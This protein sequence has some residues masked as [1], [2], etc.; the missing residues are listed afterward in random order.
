MGAASKLI[1]PKLVE[2]K[3]LTA[4]QL[5]TALAQQIKTGQALCSCAV[6][7]GFCA[8]DAALPFLAQELELGHVVL[9][10]R[11]IP[12][13]VVRKVPA[14]LAH[15]YQ[16]IPVEMRN[17]SLAIAINDPTDTH[18]LDEIRMLLGVH[19]QPQL[20]TNKDI[21]EAIKRYYGIGSDTVET[22]MKE[23]DMT[24][25]SSP[26]QGAAQD[27][28]TMAE[29]A[30]IIKF[31]N[32]I[33]LEAYRDR[34][35]D[36]HIEP[37]QDELKIRYR[38]DGILYDASIPPNIRHFQSTIVSRIKI[39]AHLNI[40]ERRL[41]Q[42]GRIK[43]KIGEE[44]LDLRVSILPTPFGESVCIRLLSAA[45]T[46]FGLDKL[47]LD[48][49]NLKTL[50]HLI[51]KPHGIILLTGPTGS[52]KTTTLYAF[53]TE[54]NKAEKKIITIEDP[55]EYQ[56][57]GI[58]QL[59]VHTKIDLSFSRALRSMLRH[60]PDI[61]M[62]G[63]IRDFETAEI[64]IR[65]ALTGHLVFSTLHTND[66]AGAVARLVD[67]GVEP[68]L[69]SSSVECIIAQRLLRTL[70][71]HC[72]E[73]VVPAAAFQKEIAAIAQAM[74]R[75]E[76]ILVSQ[77]K[78]CTRCKGTGYFGRTAIHEILVVDDDLRS[79]I[80]Q[81][82]PANVIRDKAIAKGMRTLRQDGWR[83]ALLGETSID[84]VLRV[85]QE[86]DSVD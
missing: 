47:G 82:V 63:E 42:D 55:I 25:M 16:I 52:G 32:Q 60:D 54:L 45:S 78:G 5:Q 75:K 67:M 24:T 22:M 51:T 6:Q 81:S 27:I 46:F 72:K 56:I 57:R 20:A 11:T 44:E 21:Q 30:S 61:M 48:P 12:Q 74:G 50:Q 31:V 86:S 76:K 79:L 35:T 10:D 38:I 70:C 23:S 17:N 3:L 85:T 59:Q 39:M 2:K 73:F 49:A 71:P 29:D 58:T 36:I 8:E 43:V 37:Y 53:L 40:A 4:A 77:P 14:K 34:A 1:G 15:H 26:D 13:D 7:L 9:R 33:L 41:P 19:I 62:V 28:D 64:T 66:A 80:V 69:V 68:Y 18:K 83:K 84:E 65:V